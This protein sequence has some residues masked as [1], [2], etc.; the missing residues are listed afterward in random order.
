LKIIEG[1]NNLVSELSTA[2]ETA[3]ENSKLR[4]EHTA[5]SKKLL[6]GYLMITDPKPVMNALPKAPHVVRNRNL[7]VSGIGCC[8][9]LIIF[10]G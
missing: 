3:T 2:S 9:F 6:Q 5:E 7:S 1:S 4:D 10:S 8:F